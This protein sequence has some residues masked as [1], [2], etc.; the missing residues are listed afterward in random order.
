MKR[1]RYRLS[2]PASVERLTRKLWEK[3]GH[4]DRHGYTDWVGEYGFGNAVAELIDTIASGE[5]KIDGQTYE[6]Q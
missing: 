4:K 3:H 5:A 2:N 1:T 6:Q